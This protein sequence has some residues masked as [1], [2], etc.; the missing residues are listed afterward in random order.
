MK[1]KQTISSIFAALFIYFYIFIHE[2]GNSNNRTVQKV[3]IEF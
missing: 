3:V 1:N 2:D